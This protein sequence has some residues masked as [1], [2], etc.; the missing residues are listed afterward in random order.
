MVPQA[1]AIAPLEACAMDSTAPIVLRLEIEP[2]P[3]PIT[4]RIADETGRTREF[5]GWIGLARAIDEVLD[6][7]I[8]LPKENHG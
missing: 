4:G 5:A 6:M 1:P 7:T 3:D 8:D 2:G